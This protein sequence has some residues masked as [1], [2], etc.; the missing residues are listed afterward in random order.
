MN[1]NMNLNNDIAATKIHL[2]TWAGTSKRKLFWSLGRRNAVINQS[3]KGNMWS[4]IPVALLCMFEIVGD[5]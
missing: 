4:A 1:E 3:P 5:G 2:C